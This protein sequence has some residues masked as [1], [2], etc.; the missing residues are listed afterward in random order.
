M[1]GCIHPQGPSPGLFLEPCSSREET[2]ADNVD[3]AA[4]AANGA[5]WSLRSWDDLDDALL[6]DSH[7]SSTATSGSLE[8]LDDFS[9]ETSLGEDFLSL[10]AP[11]PVTTLEEDDWTRQSAKVLDCPAVMYA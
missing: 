2:N 5:D 10:F 1:C 3:D 6:L 9:L 7:S 8:E 4:K 11:S